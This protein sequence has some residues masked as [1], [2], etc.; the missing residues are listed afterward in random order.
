MLRGVPATCMAGLRALTLAL[1]GTGRAQ[2]AATMQRLTPS[3][4]HGLRHLH[5]PGVAGAAGPSG[6]G[7]SATTAA[8][9]PTGPSAQPTPRA[10]AA[11][12][13]FITPLG[14]AGGGGARNNAAPLSDGGG[15][16]RGAPGPPSTSSRGPQGAAALPDSLVFKMLCEHFARPL[17]FGAA[18]ASAAVPPAPRG[19]YIVERLHSRTEQQAATL[20]RLQTHRKI[21][22]GTSKP[23][24]REDVQARD[25]SSG[26]P[27]P[28]ARAG[29]PLGRAL[30]RCPVSVSAARARG[31]FLFQRAAVWPLCCHFPLYFPSFACSRACVCFCQAARPDCTS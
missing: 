2:W 15:L 20:R 18:A 28:M 6:S 1:T 30:L 21:C 4:Q 19:P 27:T 22:E 13:A 3:S 7:A 25:A 14:Q 31:G 12:C 24:L 17:A 16:H 11:A 29:S 10:N 5:A 23:R 9:S 26:S 8:D